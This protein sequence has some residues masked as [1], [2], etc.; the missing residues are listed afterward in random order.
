[1]LLANAKRVFAAVLR[2][3][4]AVLRTPLLHKLFY[5]LTVIISILLLT[6]YGRKVDEEKEGF[7]TD[8]HA[9]DS[10]AANS[11]VNALAEAATG[12]SNSPS[13]QKNKNKRKFVMY[14]NPREIYDPFYV[15]I[16]DDLLFS[17]M[18]NDF[19]IGAIVQRTSPTARS[20]VLDI[21][22]GVGHHVS[23]LSAQGIKAVQGIDIAPAMIQQAKKNYP[24][25]TFSVGDALQQ[26]LFPSQSFT[27]ITCLYFTIYYMRDKVQFF[28]NCF[29]WLQPG[30]YLV[31]HVVDPVHFDP[32]IPAGDPF[33]FVSPQTYATERITSS[34]VQF[35]NIEYKSNFALQQD[36]NGV[37]TPNA[38]LSE[39]FKF[40]T[41]AGKI[42]KNEHQLYMP[43]ESEIINM[44]K[45]QG[46]VVLA[47]VDMVK[48]QY[49]YQYMYILQK[50]S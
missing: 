34:V 26:M 8:S 45:A 43:T 28:R 19:E 4:A 46:F 31:V 13:Q 32:I 41:P 7:V 15:A 3:F 6:N 20:R 44:A 33:K 30:G 38:T 17:K 42:R 22:C 49:A 21:G 2:M 16:Y 11:H 36:N 12:G 25:L 1:M 23:S 27:H 29:F 40:T 50:P 48:C 24:K 18:K 5:V 47:K 39:T 9:A 35:D 10:H 37:Q 14:T